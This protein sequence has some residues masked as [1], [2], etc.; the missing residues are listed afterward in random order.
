MYLTKI[1]LHQV[2]PESY[3]RVVDIKIQGFDYNC[4]D[5]I[6]ISSDSFTDILFVYLFVCFLIGS[7]TKWMLFLYPLQ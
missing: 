2:L 1:N 6:S 7:H 3:P 5:R 4:D